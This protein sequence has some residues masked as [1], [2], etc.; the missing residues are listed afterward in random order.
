M[1]Q[2][3]PPNLTGLPRF[4][5]DNLPVSGWETFR[6][7]V[8]TQMVRI[9]G[10]FVVETRE[11]PLVCKDGWLARDSAGWPYPIAADEQAAIYEPVEDEA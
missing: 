11:G 10:A 5:H 3:A 8:N 7:K 1:T 2:S 4:S 6:K 9:N